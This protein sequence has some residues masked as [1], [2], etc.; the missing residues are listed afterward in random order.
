MISAWSRWRYL[1][2]TAGLLLYFYPFLRVLT[3]TPDE[4]W[5]LT[6]AARVYHGQ[7][8]YR[9]FFEFVGPGT[10]Y[11][12]AL[13]LSYSARPGWRRA[14]ACCSTARQPLFWFTFWRAG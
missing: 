4:G 11:W 8:P 7:L 3:L 13:F 9:E 1:V 6:D 2:V 5:C 12:I 10:F 14:L